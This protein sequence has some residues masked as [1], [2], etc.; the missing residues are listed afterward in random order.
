[1]ADTSHSLALIVQFRGRAHGSTKADIRRNSSS[2][3]SSRTPVNHSTSVI[4][5]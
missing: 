5:S 4:N 3:C 1:M 2:S